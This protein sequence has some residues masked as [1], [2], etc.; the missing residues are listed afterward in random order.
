VAV[1]GVVCIHV[2]GAIVTNP[3]RRGSAGWWVAVALDFGNVWV[4]PVFVMVSGALLL[5]GRA[6]ANGVG[7]F[8]RTRLLRLGPAFVF[9]QLFYIFAIR[10][11][12]SG[13][14]PTAGS[15]AALFLS[16]STYTHLYF[17]WLIVGLY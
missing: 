14:E 3:D 15:V 7:A 17:L 5:G 11:L 9:W 1:L 10:W 13:Q 2:F 4:V 6:H 16:G 12:V 8:Y